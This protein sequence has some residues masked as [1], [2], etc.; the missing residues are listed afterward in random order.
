MAGKER[1]ISVSS[2]ITPSP[3]STFSL[4]SSSLTLIF[5]LSQV[6]EKTILKALKKAPKKD[7][8][9]HIVPN[10]VPSKRSF[11]I[12][13]PGLKDSI[14]SK[15]HKASEREEVSQIKGFGAGRTTQNGLSKEDVSS[16]VTMVIKP[17]VVKI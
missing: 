17:L 5:S 10:Q 4:P 3:S 6:W 15:F 13:F 11:G 16:I 8:V 9:Y 12:D 14:P 2:P 1:E 7:I